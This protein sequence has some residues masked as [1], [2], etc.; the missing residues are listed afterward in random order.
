MDEHVVSRLAYSCMCFF[1]STKQP[2]RMFLPLYS[3]LSKSTT[4]GFQFFNSYL[5]LSFL[6]LLI[7]HQME[8]I[9]S[10]DT[11]DHAQQYVSSHVLR[12]FNLIPHSQRLLSYHWHKKRPNDQGICLL[13]FPLFWAVYISLYFFCFR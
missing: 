8:I 6:V 10:T 3:S 2:F 4:K 13:T 12:S 7:C 5:V 1:N 9:L 11:C